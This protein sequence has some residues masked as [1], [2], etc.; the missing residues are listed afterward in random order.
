MR[1]KKLIVGNWKMNPK[2]LPLARANFLT[3]KKGVGLYK[4]VEAVIAAPFVYISELSKLKSAGLGLASQ[5]VSAEK[6]G[7]HT[8]EIS[9]SMLASY[10]VKYCI[11]G[12]SE[13][14][15]IGETNEFI[16]KK[17]KQLLAVGITPVLCIGE[18][19]RDHGMIYLG[20]VKTQLEECLVGISK[21]TI[22]KIVIAYEPVWAISTT[23]NRRDATPEDC[24]EMHMYIR[25]VLSDMYG[26]ANA[27]TVTI[28]YGGSVDEKTAVGFLKAGHVDGL[29]PGRASLT[30]KTF[31]TILKV[32]NLS[33]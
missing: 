7:A 5:N 24:Q 20:T 10:K 14:R 2:T 12:H 21:N 25:K 18:R 26:H 27:E 30:P 15:D 6:E 22:G 28:L 19:D 9:A 13:R 16:N 32:A 29:L 4:N 11:V 31:L 23:V 1:K 8:G 33:T 3:I 17:I